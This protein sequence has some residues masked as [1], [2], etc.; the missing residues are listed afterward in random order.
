[1]KPEASPTLPPEP[2]EIPDPTDLLELRVY[3]TLLGTGAI[4]LTP[5]KIDLGQGILTSLATIV[6]EELDVD[7]HRI[8]IEAAPI[9]IRFGKL[10]T[11]GSDSTSEGYNR[12]RQAAT[13]ARARLV[14]AAAQVWQVAPDNCIHPTDDMRFS[15]TDLLLATAEM[16][17]PKSRM[18]DSSVYSYIGKP[19][20]RREIP[21]IASGTRSLSIT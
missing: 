12:L 4:T 19:I 11:V 18:K 1:V 13:E 3:L 14:T 16:A 7:P 2:T 15:F 10:R 8:E 5:H 9:H 17:W 21:Q 20:G 6:A